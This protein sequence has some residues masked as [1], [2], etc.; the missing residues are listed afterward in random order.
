MGKVE[1]CD[2][3]SMGIA[4]I[5]NDHKKLLSLINQISDAID[6]QQTRQVISDIFDQLEHY[7]IQHFAREE[8]LLYRCQYDDIESHIKSHQAFSQKIAELK[9]L[10]LTNSSRQVAE[11]V[12]QLLINW[13]INH[14]VAEDLRY[15]PAL[16]KHNLC[17]DTE[18][19]EQSMFNRYAGWLS[20]SLVLNK[21]IL[22]T[23]LLPFVGILLLSST[24]IWDGVTK[25]NKIKTLKGLSYLTSYTGELIHHLQV[26]R[27]LSTG[28]ISSNYQDFNDALKE[29]RSLSD[30]AS[31]ALNKHMLNL[32]SKILSE[33]FNAQTARIEER[34]SQLVAIRQQVD[35]KVISIKDMKQYYTTVIT[36]L[37]SIPDEIIHNQIDSELTNRI[38]A[39]SAIMHL[40][41][42]VGLE[43]A[44]GTKVIENG[45]LAGD[46]LRTFIQ[47]IG[48]QGG[49]LR[50]FQQ[51]AT[52]KAW[53]RWQLIDTDEV[54][55][56]VK[57]FE[58]KLLS[59][60]DSG[61]VDT[62][63]SSAWFKLVSLKMDELKIL[64]DYLVIDLEEHATKK[65]SVL[66]RDLFITISIL[67]S[68]LVLAIGLSKLLTR[69]ITQPIHRLTHAMTHLSTGNR[70]IRLTNNLAKDELRQM[71]AAY[72]LCR[73]GLLKGDLEDF[74]LKYKSRESDFYKGLASIDPLTGAYNRR[75][76]FTRA[77]AEQDRSHRYKSPLSM[78][79]LDLDYFKSINDTYGHASGDLVLQTFAKACK[80]QLRNC[81]IFARIGG[82]EFAII[83]PETSLSD[84]FVLAERIRSETKSM[85]F[86]LKEQAIYLTVS[87]GIAQLK[88]EAFEEFNELF[89]RADNS[90]YLAKS[91]GRDRV[92]SSLENAANV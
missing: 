69:S 11:E 26:E 6:S 39:F 86:T 45:M 77:N 81:D 17:D 66:N 13:L 80:L 41:E 53:E 43:R 79:M 85:A 20:R 74:E 61:K 29:Q 58:N 18:K 49:F 10:L 73:L 84:A 51:T 16:N 37:L 1:W 52:P 67:F 14:I 71:G 89:E 35:S 70:D 2:G 30:K 62:L 4:E 24:I 72:E 88:H 23:A 87:I 22:L 32:S 3:L 63:D 42:A 19:D 65:I 90:L 60:A 44:L 25:L 78:L 50:I 75:E 31:N 76:L 92:S 57:V 55:I 56:A 59:A 38:L 7:T 46:D 27:G 5:D 33:K 54:L 83:L 15:I 21:R 12:S 9:N 8:A 48:K 68:L 28:V 36:H 64:S 40:K 47:F 34:L 82:E 91:E